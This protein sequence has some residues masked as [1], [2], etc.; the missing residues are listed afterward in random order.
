MEIMTDCGY[1]LHKAVMISNTNI[2]KIEMNP[3]VDN[4]DFS[5]DQQCYSIYLVQSQPEKDPDDTDDNT[6]HSE[7]TM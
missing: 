2:T 6:C 3:N 4:L 5:D 1:L 7:P